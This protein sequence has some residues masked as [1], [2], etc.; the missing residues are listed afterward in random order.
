MPKELELSPGG[1]N[2]YCVKIGVLSWRLLVNGFGSF[3]DWHL[4]FLKQLARHGHPAANAL[5]GLGLFHE[6][7]AISHSAISIG[8]YVALPI[9]YCPP[10]LSCCFPDA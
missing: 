2:A 8:T 5:V 4:Y 3:R 7:G 6:H 10:V 9:K 1:G